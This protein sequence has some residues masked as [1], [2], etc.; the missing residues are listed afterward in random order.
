MKLILN[1]TV[2]DLTISDFA[3]TLVNDGS[4][5]LWDNKTGRVFGY[6]GTLTT[7]TL[8]TSPLNAHWIKP[9]LV[10]NRYSLRFDPI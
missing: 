3:M 2:T 7:S 9:R 5:A 6:D 1:K 10:P 8:C 4:N